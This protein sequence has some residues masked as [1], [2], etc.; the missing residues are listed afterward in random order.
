M[1]QSVAPGRA[2]HAHALQANNPASLLRLAEKKKEYEAVAALELASALFVKR[3]EGLADDYD[4][5]A[6]AGQGMSARAWSPPL[7]I[8]H[9]S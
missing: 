9:R 4:V 1:R 8:G 3:L 6:D 7:L 5:M 2:S